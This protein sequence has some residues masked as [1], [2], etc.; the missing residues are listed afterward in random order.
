MKADRPRECARGPAS[1]AG[2]Y[3]SNP[4][5]TPMLVDARAAAARL[6]IGR[7]RLWALTACNAIPSRR[8][9]RSVRYALAELEAWIEAGCP[10]APGSADRVRRA[11]RR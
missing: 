2:A 11:V 1:T 9:G 3:E 6:A 5:C 7:R 10:T 4:D 8:I